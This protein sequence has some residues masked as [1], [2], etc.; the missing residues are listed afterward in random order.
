M[1]K[2]IDGKV[3]DTET[4]EQI[5][6]TTFSKYGDLTYWSEKLYRTRKG[7]WFIA[8][9]GGAM[10]PY[11]RSIGQNEIGG[12]SAIIPLTRVKALSWLEAHT[13]DS[14]AVEKYFSDVFEKG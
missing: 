8:G 11:A 13:P 1:K 3:Y 5:A 9:E 7:N 2:V 12:G 6:S 10:S 14:E 4:A